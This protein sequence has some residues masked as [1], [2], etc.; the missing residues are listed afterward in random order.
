[1]S[2]RARACVRGQLFPLYVPIMRAQLSSVCACNFLL[3]LSGERWG[4]VNLS[5]TGASWQ[6]RAFQAGS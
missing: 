3:F 5:V 6:G 4:A 2:V 1:M